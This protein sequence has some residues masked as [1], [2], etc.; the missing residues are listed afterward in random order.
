MAIHQVSREHSILHAFILYGYMYVARRD[1]SCRYCYDLCRE[2]LL[3][4]LPAI[5]YMCTLLYV[6][7][8]SQQTSGKYYMSVKHTTLS[9]LPCR[10]SVLDSIVVFSVLVHDRPTMPCLCVFV[11]VCAKFGGLSRPSDFTNTLPPT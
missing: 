3:F 2:L 1:E 5:W 10:F 11:S 9:I 7:C 4:S 6:Y 8:K